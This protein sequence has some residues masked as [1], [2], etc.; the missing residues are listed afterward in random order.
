[1]I[2]LSAVGCAPRL[3]VGEPCTRNGECVEGHVCGVGGRCREECVVSA[4]CILGA[5]CLRDPV[6]NLNGCS[7]ATDS[8]SA[9]TCEGGLRCVEGECLGVCLSDDE[10][11]DDVCRD[12]ACEVPSIATDAGEEADAG[13]ELD[14]D[15]DGG[16]GCSNAPSTV[17]DISVGHEGACAA[18]A[19][20]SVYCW[21]NQGLLTRDAVRDGCGGFCA[22]RPQRVISSTGPLT[23]MIEVATGGDRACARNAA[24]DV[25]CWAD[26]GLASRMRTRTDL[27]V[28]SAI[29]AGRTHA[30]AVSSDPATM[31]GVFCWGDSAR[32]QLGLGALTS[33]AM[34]AQAGDLT[35]TGISLGTLHTLAWGATAVYGFGENEYGMLGVPYSVQERTPVERPDV[36]ATSVAAGAANTCVR[37]DGRVFCWGLESPILGQV[38]HTVE[39][40]NGSEMCTLEAVQLIEITDAVGLALDPY[41]SAAVAWNAEGAAVG[42]GSSYT[43][44]LAAPVLD[45]PSSLTALSVPTTEVSLGNFAACALTPSTG[46]GVMCWGLNTNGELGRGYVSE[47]EERPE[48][49]VAAPLCW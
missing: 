36:G 47:L 5:R 19:D 8:C 27:L 9:G 18:L 15:R 25:W 32:G 49:I 1:M 22:T 45:V 13:T 38:S 17:V 14:A 21:G 33:S 24:G 42:W 2:V 26:L 20:G 48:D 37:I 3:S 12:G 10:C 34:A 46:A 35:A 4:D 16:M 31:G 23:G 43:G 29:S 41:G 7:L 40:C 30:C 28:A 39:P 44:V 11:P 6:S